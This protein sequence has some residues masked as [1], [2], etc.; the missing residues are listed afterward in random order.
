MFA[1]IRA[2]CDL[3][4]FNPELLQ[5]KAY[6]FISKCSSLP[7]HSF[8]LYQW[9]KKAIKLSGDATCSVIAGACNE[10]ERGRRTPNNGKLLP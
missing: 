5:A 3:S 7:L 8:I 2:T 6:H 9:G 1:N 10:L 4:F